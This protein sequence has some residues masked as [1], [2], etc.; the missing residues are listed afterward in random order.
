MLTMPAAAHHIIHFIL[1]IDFFVS[2]MLN[3]PDDLLNSACSI[4]AGA[5]QGE[6]PDVSMLLRLS[7]G[8]IR[9]PPSK[10][11]QV[12]SLEPLRSCRILLTQ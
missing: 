8:M 12:M 7:M 1:K 11:L 2:E 5:A 9:F 10:L 4:R 3:L 6:R